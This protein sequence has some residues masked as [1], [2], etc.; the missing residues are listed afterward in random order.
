MATEKD[1]VE[2]ISS[3]K[4][5]P[6]GSTN[7]RVWLMQVEAHFHARRITS[8]SARYYYLVEALPT[9]I[10]EQLVDLI[11]PIPEV[12]P[13][14]SLKAALLERTTA[15]EDLRLQHLLSGVEIGDR[16][17]SQL[18][19][20][21]RALVGSLKVDDSILRQLWLKRLSKHAN[22][23]LSTSDPQSKLEDLA[24][25]ADKIH[26]CFSPPMV[27]EVAVPAA[28]S[29]SNVRLEQIEQQLA[30]LTAT[31][32]NLAVSNNRGRSRSRS[33]G[34]SRSQSRHSNNHRFCR[35]HR[36]FGDQAKHC[37]TPCSY[38]AH[39]RMTPSGNGPASQ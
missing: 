23:I 33:F 31:I 26:E 10:A 22:A 37:R 4:L 32:S 7:P 29:G 20:H 39:H 14:E 38:K 35:Y 24:R 12:N 2:H 13:Y 5:P 11:D 15:S 34:S 28:P 27:S 8:Q 9:P 19:R 36:K 3:V 25:M 16:T 21:M 30:I 17:P 18:L 1:N 6:F